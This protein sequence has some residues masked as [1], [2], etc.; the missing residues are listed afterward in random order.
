MKKMIL[1]L[2]V[3]LFWVVTNS[4]AQGEYIIEVDPATGTF[5]KPNTPING[6]TWVQG[7]V[8]TYD[9]I[10]GFY[11]FPATTI[12][13]LITVDS[14]DS[15]IFNPPF[16]SILECQYDNSSGI[17]YG[18]K[19][20][21]SGQFVFGSINPSTANHSPIGAGPIS[22]M[23]GLYQGMSTFDKNAHRYIIY[24]S[25]NRLFSINAITGN[26]LSNPTVMLNPGEILLHISY[27]DDNNQLYGLIQNSSQTFLVQINTTSG[28]VTKIG[29][30]IAFGPGG[31]TSTID[32]MNR[33]Y[34]FHYSL[35][36]SYFIAVI[37]ITTGN[38]LYNNQ[39][40]FAPGGNINSIQYDNVKK[41]LYAQ[42]WEAPRLL[43]I[44]TFSTLNALAFY[45]NPFSE[46][47]TLKT[48]YSLHNATLTVNNSFGQ[49]VMQVKNISGQ[50]VTLQRGDLPSGLYFLHLTESNQVIAEG[51]F[52]IVDH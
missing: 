38:L 41:K 43:G 19:N 16:G 14:N 34:I 40:L 29:N 15:I 25:E 35:D 39:V 26:V 8:S 45:P 13:G 32:Q 42:H 46:Q 49:T 21:G 11:I 30:G 18:L 44:N 5:I 20:S 3:T 1:G 31:G 28:A 52:V 2:I 22:G 6:V 12:N 7:Y 37:D 36:L 4:S 23:S 50:T 17:L 9:E 48:D 33:Y 24:V 47:T 51:K 10:H 27:D